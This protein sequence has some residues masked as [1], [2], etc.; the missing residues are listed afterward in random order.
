MTIIDDLEP[1]A[2]QWR[3]KK[4]PI[5]RIE[6]AK[7]LLNLVEKHKPSRILEL[8]TAVGYSGTILASQKG[9]A[10]V[11]IDQD[12]N[13]LKTAE[14]TFAKFNV[15]AQIIEEDVIDAL[16]DITQLALIPGDFDMIFI[17]HMKAKYL[18]SLEYC[19][20]LSKKGTIIIADNVKNPKCANFV[21]TIKTDARLSTEII[22]IDDGLSLSVVK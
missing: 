12:A 6:S 17:D 16:K 2:I 7:W 4:I 10:L 14:E 9:T 13:A 21:S 8:G 11:T 19:I 22:D 1:L 3:G 15:D 20:K 5:I 18:E